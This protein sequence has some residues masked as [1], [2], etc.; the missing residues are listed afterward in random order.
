MFNQNPQVI[1]QCLYAIALQPWQLTCGRKHWRGL[2]G[3]TLEVNS[4]SLQQTLAERGLGIVELAERF[5]SK[6]I[7]QGQL[8]PVLPDWQA[9]SVTIWCITP[10]RRLLP[11][12]SE[13]FIETLR[14]VLQD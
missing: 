9:P 12:R 3:H 8:I 1:V 14:E 4:L 2:P 5:A 10:G 6:A 11:K 7:E 13:A